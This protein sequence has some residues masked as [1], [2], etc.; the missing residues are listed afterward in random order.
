ML[1][2]HHLANDHI[3]SQEDYQI[4]HQRYQMYNTLA[5]PHMQDPSNK[6]LWTNDFFA[7]L[8]ALNKILPTVKKFWQK[9]NQSPD[10]TMPKQRHAF[11]ENLDEIKV[12]VLKIGNAFV[13]ANNAIREAQK[14]Q[15]IT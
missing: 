4:A 3:F 9:Y 8:C 10:K 12:L 15:S 13:Q 11:F 5:H 1:L 7:A 6:E 2:F 14:H